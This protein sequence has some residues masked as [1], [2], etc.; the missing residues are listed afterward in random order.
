MIEPI[1][2]SSDKIMQ[3]LMDVMEL[4]NDKTYG[5]E[6]RIETIKSELEYETFELDNLPINVDKCQK[7]QQL[8]LNT[9]LN[10]YTL[11][12][13]GLT[14]GVFTSCLNKYIAQHK[15]IDSESSKVTLT[16]LLKDIFI[17]ESSKNK[18]SYNILLG[19]I[20]KLFG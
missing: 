5:I 14:V 1:E 15:L 16:P 13:Q 9:F 11:D 10:K 4:F 18:V 8:A 19:S 7:Q 17:F 12:S 2:D 3:D 6:S 20:V